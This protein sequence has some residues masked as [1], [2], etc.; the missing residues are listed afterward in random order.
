MILSNEPGYY[1]DGEFGIRIESLIVVRPVDTP[2]RFLGRQY[3]GFETITMVPIQRKMIDVTLLSDEELQWLNQF[4][5]DCRA[6]LKD[7]LEGRA[8]DWLMRETEPIQRQ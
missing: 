7:R 5:A 6:K 8:R 2:N 1:Q 3:L 4:H